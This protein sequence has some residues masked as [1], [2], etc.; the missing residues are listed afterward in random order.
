M[1]PPD[2]GLSLTNRFWAKIPKFPPSMAQT[3]NVP[4]HRPLAAAP[5]EQSPWKTLPCA[6]PR[7]WE[8]TSGVAATGARP[9]QQSSL[10]ARAS[11]NAHQLPGAQG[12]SR[13]PAKTWD[14][15]TELGHNRAAS[16]EPRWPQAPLSSHIRGPRS[17]RR[18]SSSW[19]T[20][21][22]FIPGFILPSGHSH[23]TNFSTD[24]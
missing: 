20:S 15:G 16:A 22:S 24:F 3:G 9:L 21:A 19:Q 10:S 11:I 5:E 18:N 8:R 23:W 4:P 17:L 13:I 7:F 12:R 6:N 1:N 14:N 2:L